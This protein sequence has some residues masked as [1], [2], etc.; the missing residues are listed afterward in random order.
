MIFSSFLVFFI[1]TFSSLLLFSVF[2]SFSPFLLL[3]LKV[4]HSILF[5]NNSFTMLSPTYS[6]LMIFLPKIFFYRKFKACVFFMLKIIFSKEKQKKKGFFFKCNK[7][8]VESV[9][10]NL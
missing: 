3:K 1:P 8:I 9:K 5:L 10:S 7:N 4:F 2:T 6:S